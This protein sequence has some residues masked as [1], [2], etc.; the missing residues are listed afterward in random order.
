[1]KNIFFPVFGRLAGVAKGVVGKG[2][3]EEG[4]IGDITDGGVVTEGGSNG[5]ETLEETNSIAVGSDGAA[6]FE[7]AI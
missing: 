1:M 5:K 4:L 3:Q 6:F 7:Y 2:P